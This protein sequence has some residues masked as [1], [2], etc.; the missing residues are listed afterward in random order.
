MYIMTALEHHYLQTEMLCLDAVLCST[1]LN[2]QMVHNTS[3]RISL[4]KEEAKLQSMYLY[5]NYLT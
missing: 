5:S 2:C 1:V 3:F 4:V